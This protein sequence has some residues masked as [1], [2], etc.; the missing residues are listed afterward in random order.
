MYVL[1]IDGGGTKT[2]GVIADASGNVYASA[3]QG[4]DADETSSS[5]VS[6]K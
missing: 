1:G 5:G 3:K 6:S 4:S 2:K